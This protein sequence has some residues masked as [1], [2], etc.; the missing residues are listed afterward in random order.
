[1]SRI[2]TMLKKG[3]RSVEKSIRNCKYNRAA[4]QTMNEKL[5]YGLNTNERKEEIVVSLTSYGERLNHVHMTIRSIFNQTYKPDK[6][7]LYLDSDV[8]V[9]D[10][11]TT[12]T[13]IK[14]YGLEIAVKKENLRSHKKYYYAVQEYPESLIVTIDDDMLYPSDLIENLVRMHEKYPNAVIA[15]RVHEILLDDMGNTMPYRKWKWEVDASESKPSY[16]YL[17]TGCGGVLYPLKSLAREM[18]NVDLIK[19]LALPADDIWLKVAEIMNHTPVKMA[20]GHM[21]KR[22][23]EEPSA[24]L[25]ALSNS[26]VAEDINDKIIKDT[27][28][29]LGWSGNKLIGE[30][31]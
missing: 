27:L 6:V 20:K 9:E 15:S 1:M 23:Y 22:T 14:K 28:G 18:F 4:R 25:I 8:S 11:P 30:N 16:T 3:K 7:I 19:N 5:E 24:D 21:W 31:E 10:L 26:N 13:E 29:Y 2:V 12:L 17:A